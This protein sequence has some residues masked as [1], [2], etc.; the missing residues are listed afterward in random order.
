LTAADVRKLKRGTAAEENNE[1]SDVE[2]ETPNP[3]AS[4]AARAS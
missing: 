1:N 3:S 2:V 4:P